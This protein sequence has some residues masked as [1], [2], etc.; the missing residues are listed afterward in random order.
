MIDYRT[1]P[2]HHVLCLDMKSFFASC[3]C[4]R[5]GLDPEEAYLAVV[6]DVH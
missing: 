2:R 3:E 6:G 1:L 5:R 4:V